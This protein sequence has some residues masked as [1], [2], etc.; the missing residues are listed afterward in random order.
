LQRISNSANS[1][2]YAQGCTSLNHSDPWT[3]F[4]SD[5]HRISEWDVSHLLCRTYYV[6]PTMW[7]HRRC[8]LVG[9]SAFDPF[10]GTL[11]VSGSSGETRAH[12][13]GLCRRCP[14]LS[15]QRGLPISGCQPSSD[16]LDDPKHAAAHSVQPKSL[17]QP[18]M[19]DLN[20]ASSA[21]AP[22]ISLPALTSVPVRL[23]L[24]TSQQSNMTYLHHRSLC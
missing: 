10:S 22:N 2:T 3:W 19:L 9:L 21:G 1:L 11:T 14:T 7:G 23:S 20:G 5:I 12:N 18:A 4:C 13:P 17:V 16:R 6:A 8:I 15:L 24:L